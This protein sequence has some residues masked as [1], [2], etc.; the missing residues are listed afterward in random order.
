MKNE[1]G[2]RIQPRRH[3]EAAQSRARFVRRRIAAGAGILAL[4]AGTTAAVKGIQS[5]HEADAL[6]G[7]LEQPYNKVLDEISQGKIDP[8]EIEAFKA[9]KPEHAYTAAEQLNGGTKVTELSDIIEAQQTDNLQKDDIYIV[10]KDD[11]GPTDQRAMS[12][13]VIPRAGNIVMS[14]NE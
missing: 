2:T 10:P 7:K 8:N 9:P 13:A 1:S 4:A 3:H 11:V 14:N 12:I 6:A 5:L